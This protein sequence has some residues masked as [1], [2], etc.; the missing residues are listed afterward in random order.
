MRSCRRCRCSHRRHCWPCVGADA[1]LTH[2][3]D[4]KSLYPPAPR[5][6][7]AAQ[8]ETAVAYT[9]TLPAVGG[10]LHAG[11]LAA[12]AA[13]SAQHHNS[14]VEPH[15]EAAGG[16]AAQSAAAGEGGMDAQTQALLQDPVV[17]E[18]RCL[19]VGQCARVSGCAAAWASV[20]CQM[21][22]LRPAGQGRCFGAPDCSA[23]IA[24]CLPADIFC[25]PPLATAPADPVLLVLLPRLRL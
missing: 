9:E 2:P 17:R 24:P 13:D 15:P 18:V 3:P 23:V 10:P 4:G 5:L 12:G 1:E 11:Q 22:A 21:L 14:F 7:P 19:P 20:G 16:S 8:I 6:L 25:S